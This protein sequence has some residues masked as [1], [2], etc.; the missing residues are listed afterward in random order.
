M[1]ASAVT[2]NQIQ[3]VMNAASHTWQKTVCAMAGTLSFSVNG[4]YPQ[5]VLSTAQTPLFNLQ[6]HSP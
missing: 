4:K 2:W 6:H 5:A 3:L 1:V